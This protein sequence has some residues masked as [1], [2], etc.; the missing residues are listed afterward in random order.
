MMHKKILLLCLSLMLFSA[1]CDGG[2]TEGTGVETSTATNDGAAPVCGTVT[3]SSGAPKPGAEVQT[4]LHHDSVM[5]DADGEFMLNLTPD[6]Q[7]SDVVATDQN[8]NTENVML[9]PCDTAI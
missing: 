3:D 9:H 1:A 2:G 7:A 4:S 5:T 8:G 6:E